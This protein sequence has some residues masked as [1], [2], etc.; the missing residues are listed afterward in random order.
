MH[1]HPCCEGKGR[2]Y[3]YENDGIW[4]DTVMHKR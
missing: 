3:N 2:V 1:R 4:N